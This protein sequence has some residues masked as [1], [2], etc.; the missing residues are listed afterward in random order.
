MLAYLR[1]LVLLVLELL[2]LLWPLIVNV[3]DSTKDLEVV[4]HNL[5][6]DRGH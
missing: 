5:H 6:V 3:G 1:H 4:S 2:D